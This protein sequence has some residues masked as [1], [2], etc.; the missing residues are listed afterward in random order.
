MVRLTFTLSP[1]AVEALGRPVV[2]QGGFQSLLRQIQALLVSNEL[3]LTP[4]LISRIVRYVQDYGGGGF[5][6]RLDTI[7]DELRALGNCLAPTHCSRVTSTA[8]SGLTQSFNSRDAHVV[9]ASSAPGDREASTTGSCS[10]HTRWLGAV[11]QCQ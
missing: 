1:D 8:R 3:T 2:G 9:P 6:N 10:N 11:E 7:L 5:Q 4:E